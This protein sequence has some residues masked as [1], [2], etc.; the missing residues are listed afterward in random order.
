MASRIASSLVSRLPLP[1]DFAQDV[2]EKIRELIPDDEESESYFDNNLMK[3]EQ[4]EQL[5]LWLNQ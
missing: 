5:L 2:K 3:R 1:H 4:D